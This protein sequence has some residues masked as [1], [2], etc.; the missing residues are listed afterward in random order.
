MAINVKWEDEQRTVIRIAFQRGWT[1]D[2][3]NKA[4][5]QAD[6]MIISVPH[7]VHL[8][9][10]IRNAGGLPRDFMTRAGD[11]FAQ[12]DARPNEGQKVVVGASW[13]IRSAYNGFRAVYGSQLQGRP[14]IFADSPED[15]QGLLGH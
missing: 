3:L 12:G 10:D 5:V 11:I 13:L 14:F 7:E 9:I 2:D 4:I 6:Q 8:L 15:A 1:W